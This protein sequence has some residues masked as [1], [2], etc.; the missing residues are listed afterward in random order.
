MRTTRLPAGH[1]VDL[2]PGPVPGFL[3][4]PG[5]ALDLFALAEPHADEPGDLPTWTPLW[6]D[7]PH[8]FIRAS[9]A[10]RRAVVA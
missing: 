5:L 8:A 1:L 7:D 4:T 3:G 10:A 2:P 6:I 9:R